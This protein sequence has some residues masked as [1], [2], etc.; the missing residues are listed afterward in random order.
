[1][2]TLAGVWPIGEERLTGYVEKALREAK[3]NT[4]WIDQNHD[5]EERVKRFAAA[6]L[7]HEP[8][9]ESFEPFVEEVAAAGERSALGQ[10]LL[11]LTVPGVPDVYQGDELID[12]SLVDPDNRRPVD[13]DARRAALA[14]LKDGAQPTRETMKLHVISRALELRARRAECFGPGGAYTPIDA[15]PEVCAFVRGDAEVIVVVALYGSTAAAALDAPAGRY[16]DVLSGREHELDRPVPVDALVEPH[17]LA[18]L[19]RV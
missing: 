1:F 10:L 19:E 8:F 5:W 16:R 9:L 14:A 15:G 17:G 3:R 7:T 2:Q 6:L 18:L 11:K 12:L 13:W 4:N